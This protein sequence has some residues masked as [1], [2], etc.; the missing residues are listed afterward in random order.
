M[1]RA[2]N[3]LDCQSCHI[4]AGT[5]QFGIPLTG[6]WGEFPQYIGRENEVRTLEER[7]NGCIERST[8]GRALPVDGARAV[9]RSGIWRRLM[10]LARP[11]MAAR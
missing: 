11:P 9:Q 10:R 7:V 1:R 2:G 8:D 6:I 5:Q 3:G 4:Q